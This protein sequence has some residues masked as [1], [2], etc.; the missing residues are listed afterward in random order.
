MQ[1]AAAATATAPRVEGDISSVFSSLNG[2][3]QQPLPQRFADLKTRLIAGREEAVQNAWREL[4]RQLKREIDEIREL[5]PAIVPEIEF[6]EIA[7][8]DGPAEAFGRR[9]K[10]TGVA[11]VRG[12]VKEEEALGWKEEI[13]EYIRK[14]PQTKGISLYPSS[15]RLLSHIC[16]KKLKQNQHS[17]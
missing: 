4:L 10:R 9:L 5:G 12:V 7:K 11:V 3:V 13:R 2:T 16:G 14:N 1:T 6:A 8:G 15:L 17:H